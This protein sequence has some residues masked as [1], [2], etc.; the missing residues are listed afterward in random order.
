VESSG[1]LDSGFIGSLPVNSQTLDLA[2][3]TA[4]HKVKAAATFCPGV[5]GMA[6]AQDPNSG[7]SQFFLMRGAHPNLD[8]QYTAAGRVIAGLDVVR[9]IKTGEPVDPPQ[10]KML[11]VRVL[12]DIPA[13]QRPTVRVIDPR[14]SW[15]QAMAK[16]MRAQS[17]TGLSL[18]DL[19][20]P[21]QVK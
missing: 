14:G 5:L 6:R 10:D 17:V 8:Q 3:L 13:A 18:C 4:D 2:L 7:N 12:A 20:L 1:G 11:T 19:D 15:F 9:S 16:R 21:S